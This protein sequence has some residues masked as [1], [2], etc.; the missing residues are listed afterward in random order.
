MIIALVLAVTLFVPMICRKIRIPGIVG[1]ILVGVAI[2]EHGFGLIDSGGAI[3]TLGKIGMLY[4]MLQAGIEVDVNDFRQ[5]RSKAALYGLYSF[6][7]PFAIGLLTSRLMGYRWVTCA[8]LGAM[9][10]SHTLMTYPIVNRYGVQKNAAVNIAIG[11]SMLTI[12][13]SLLVLAFLKS[14]FVYTDQQSTWILI[15]KIALT[16]GLI[17]L[18]FPWLTKRFFKR[19]SDP[20]TGFLVVMTLMVISALLADW[21]GMEGILGAFICG[22]A[23]NKLVP[24]LSPVMQRINFVGNNIFVPLFL[25]GVGMMIDI[26]LL[27]SGWATII[28]AVVM[29]ATK[30]AGKW[31]AAWLAQISFGLQ[32]VERQLIFGLTHATAAGTLAI[33]TIGYETGIF[34]AQILNAAVVMILALCTSSSFV[35]EYAAKQ[36]ALQE[37]ARLESEKTDNEWLMMTVGENRHYELQE[38]GELSEL[39]EPSLASESDWSEAMDLIHHQRKAALIYH[40]TQPI[41]TINR[42]L[43]AVPRYAEKEHDFIT[44][45]GLIRRLSSQLGARVVFFTNE[46]TQRTLQAFCKRKGKY[47]RASYREME[48]WEDVLMIAKQ[49]APD[50]MIVMINARPSTPSY[51][52]LFEQ[53]P[54]ML[55]KFFAGHSYLLVYPEQETGASVPDLLT[56]D[57]TQASKTW[58]IVSAIKNKA[59][60]ILSK[61]QLK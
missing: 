13:L 42:L 9:Y 49:M 59:K 54:K 23:M 4:I 29:I 19:W 21:C 11:G 52:P 12:S 30:L 39:K 58:S 5:Q 36:L 38:L 14:N 7:V 41:N 60:Q 1:F 43:V 50:D 20:T 40:P 18:V 24:N 34:D 44:C 25:L 37:E 10:G 15:G 6:I 53:V 56:G 17:M 55:E 45:F 61:I 57:T 8:L 28:I 16:V 26:S 22:V 2:G 35:T 46:D 47:L 51:N 31:L 33:V 27:W 3:Q 32:P 48:D